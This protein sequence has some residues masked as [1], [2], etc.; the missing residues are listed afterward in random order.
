[1]NTLTPHACEL[2]HYEILKLS[3]YFLLL[4]QSL[5]GFLYLSNLVVNNTD[6]I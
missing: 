5:F 2:V 1:M 4:S 6:V 3:I